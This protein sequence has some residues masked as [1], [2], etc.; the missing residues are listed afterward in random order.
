[1]NIRLHDTRRAALPS[2]SSGLPPA[3]ARSGIALVITLI[4]LAVTLVMAVTFL[5]ISSRERG[6]VTTSTDANHARQAA[7]AA[8]A[9]AQAQIVASILASTNPYNFG[10][11]VSTN[12]QNPNGFLTSAGVGIVSPTNVSYYYG[13]GAFLNAADLLVNIGN[14]QY[15]PRAPV[16]VPTNGNQGYD[17]RFFLDLNR[18][19]Q[20][21][22]SGIVPN[23]IFSNNAYVTN[24]Y[25]GK[26]GDPQWIGVLEHP[27][28]PHG[29]ANRFI[30]RYSF[31]A[32]P[33]GNTLD[34]NAIY[35]AAT[36]NSNSTPSITLSPGYDSY[37]R[38]QGVGSWELNLAAFLADL[39]TN[40]WDPPIARYSYNT[41]YNLSPFGVANLANSGFAFEDALGILRY[42]Y[43]DTV[44]SQP[45]L[46]QLY[47]NSPIFQVNN[48]DVYSQ[49]AL[50]TNTGIQYPNG[51]TNRPWSGAD[52]TNHF[53]SL[54]DYFNPNIFRPA[55][56]G[57]LPT[58]KVFT[59][60]LLHAGT[61]SFPSGN[62]NQV[63]T[64]NRYTFTT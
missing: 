19:G 32:I 1:M 45:L 42:R 41:P 12:Y 3:T 13:N 57:I 53:F 20:F 17:F 56:Y 49:G 18:N 26:L 5:A 33:V 55:G 10:M 28:A 60:R 46:S 52:T 61:N 64:Y 8:L 59:D 37:I 29:P 14:L 40:E 50:V 44:Y 2:P 31:I 22:N 21:E 62:P 24:G 30:A 58:T 27:D 34:V 38:N 16:F 6:S 7:D 39:N 54:D 4:M 23:T 11:F 43:N 9:N 35:N 47:N 25:I 15:L 51:F 63:P 48:L 36:F